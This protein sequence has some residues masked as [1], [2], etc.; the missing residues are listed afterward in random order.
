MR[1]K[2]K[3]GNKT[4]IGDGE[5]KTPFVNRENDVAILQG[6]VKGAM[7]RKGNLLLIEG[8]IGIGKSRL[9]EE[10]HRWIEESNAE[11]RY[12]TSRCMHH[13]SGDPYLPFMDA[14]KGYY[15]QSSGWYDVTPTLL[16]RVEDLDDLNQPYL[17]TPA[18]GSTKIIDLDHLRQ[19]RDQMFENTTQLLINIASEKPLI[20]FLDDIH[21]ADNP[22]LHL[23]QYLARHTKNAGVLIIG[24]YRPEELQKVGGKAHPLIEILHRM[25]RE[26]LMSKISLRRLERHDVEKMISLIFGRR[27]L[28]QGFINHIYETTEGNPYFVE[29]VLR[30]FMEEKIVDLADKDWYRT[31]DTSQ[32]RVPETIKDV[33]IRRINRLE[34]DAIKVLRYAALIGRVFDYRVLFRLMGIDEERLLDCLDDLVGAR[35]IHEDMESEEETYKFDNTIINDVACA[36]LS[37]SRRRVVHRKIA[38]IIENLY[39]DKTALD[40]YDLARHFYRGKDY[41]KAAPYLISAGKTAESLYALA[42]AEKYYDLAFKALSELDGSLDNRQRMITVFGRLGRICQIIGKWQMAEEYHKKTLVQLEEAKHEISASASEPRELGFFPSEMLKE[43]WWDERRAE[44]YRELGYIKRYQADWDEAVKYYDEALDI[45]SGT[46]DLGGIAE[47][48]RGLGY[49]H[50]RKGEYDDAISHY[51]ESIDN[52]EKINDP[53]VGGVLFIE[54]G[55]V[56]NS[57]GDW[58]RAVEYYEKSIETL[59]EQG[60]LREMGRAYNNLGD[61]YIQREDWEKA[62]MYCKRSEDTSRKIGS[63]YMMG[64]SSFNQAECYA[65]TGD[66]NKALEKNDSALELLEPLKDKVGIS[67][68]YRNYGTIYRLKSDWDRAVEYFEKSISILSE[69]D[70]PFEMG[71]ANYE[72]GMMYMD[73]GDRKSAKPCMKKALEC[74]EKVG[75]R[76]RVEIIRSQW[77]DL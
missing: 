71:Y 42:E 18:V 35:L 51:K 64:W 47:A 40:I 67:A 69:L 53:A 36:D 13:G 58:L 20:L 26:K 44:A 50:W 3:G 41:A 76:K 16:M 27:G 30:S 6:L 46:G 25:K 15:E 5:F 28:P 19:E 61:I 21:W 2:I 45:A 48:N 24:A 56:Y 29:E 68:I 75:A 54:L 14:L 77:K 23:I 31:I 37:R 39:E 11:I 12:L 43:S 9:V 10:I 38:E 57:Q 70:T 8:E 32:V 73:K 59:G 33:I 52:I 74:F 55:N 63:K 65:N 62:I 34:K 60:D 17:P 72:Y 7:K 4:I 1:K 49:I 66:F 22:S